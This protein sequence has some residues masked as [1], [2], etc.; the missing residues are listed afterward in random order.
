MLHTSV[1]FAI[2]DTALYTPP[3]VTRLELLVV[4]VESTAAQL[5]VVP[6]VVRNLP[7]LPVCGGRESVVLP[8]TIK[9]AIIKHPIYK[10]GITPI[11]SKK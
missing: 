3:E 4:G 11:S 5:A 10:A 9:L 6:F 8:F 1:P 2:E 7:L